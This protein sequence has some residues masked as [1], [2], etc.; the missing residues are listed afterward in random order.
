[1]V[2][3][4]IPSPTDRLSAKG[5]S[6]VLTKSG[7]VLI[8][9]PSAGTTLSITNVDISGV[10]GNFNI[11]DGALKISGTSVIDSSKNLVNINRISMTNAETNVIDSSSANLTRFRF[12][13]SG[14]GNCVA[15]VCDMYISRVVMYNNIEV[16][17]ASGSE[18]EKFTGNY[19]SYYSAAGVYHTYR[20]SKINIAA[21]MKISSGTGGVNL[22][23]N[24]TK[25][26]ELE[27]SSASYEMQFGTYNLIANERTNAWH[28]LSVKID[29]D[30][31]GTIALKGL[32]VSL[33]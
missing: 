18:V 23:I 8:L 13:N 4:N 12:H 3:P 19:P 27:T 10:T 29:N 26:V 7:S 14:A 20:P 6:L 30:S 25:R 22:Y 1:M 17:D 21:E 11:Q 2:R 9:T 5:S 24:G 16:T 32:E 28:D 33:S 31:A 15:T